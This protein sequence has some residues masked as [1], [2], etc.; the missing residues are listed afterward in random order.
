MFTTFRKNSSSA[1]LDRIERIREE[2]RR[3]RL[4]TEHEETL[5]CDKHGEVTVWVKNGETLMNGY[6]CPHCAA[7][8]QAREE[9]K[10]KHKAEFVE[11][12]N[13]SVTKLSEI[14]GNF[15]TPYRSEQTFESYQ[16]SGDA[17]QGR[18]VY[19]CKRFAERFYVRLASG[20]AEKSRVG[21]LF[22]GEY[23]TGKTHLANGICNEVMKQGFKPIF[24]TAQTLFNFFRPSARLD[25][26][27]LL[28]LL[29]KA[30]L[31]VLDEIGRSSG[32]E[33][34]RNQ[35]IELLDARAR[36]GNPT[37][38]ISNLSTQAL[39]DELGMALISRVQTYFFPLTFD[40][41]DFRRK[42]TVLKET[43]DTLF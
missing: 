12:S 10:A 34:E 31:L 42:K 19:A 41:G 6:E 28:H 1:L 25:I 32:S 37:I 33:F 3:A 9:E 15:N 18:A 35:L 11:R 43:P 26:N 39:S 29:A 22:R 30:P 7:E 4:E 13:R 8:R 17:K 14:L 21:L 23:G 2:Q 16:L 40:W 38:L 5:L 36:N 24:M 20:D 27:D